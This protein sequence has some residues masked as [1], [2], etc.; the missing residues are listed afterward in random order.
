M[1]VALFILF[2]TLYL[3][4][5]SQTVWTENNNGLPTKPAS[6]VSLTSDGTTLLASNKK[7][8]SVSYDEGNTW[9]ELRE[10]FSFWDNHKFIKQFGNRLFLSTDNSGLMLSYDG[11]QSW[12]YAS[13]LPLSKSVT[14]MAEADTNFYLGTTQGVYTMSKADG[15][16]MPLSFGISSDTYINDV[17][18]ANNVIFA[19]TNFGVYLS[20]NWGKTWALASGIPSDGSVRSIAALQNTIVVATSKGLFLSKD[21]GKNWAV[22]GKTILNESTVYSVASYNNKVFILTLT[23][24]YSS[25]DQGETWKIVADNLN[26]IKSLTVQDNKLFLLTN[27]GLFKLDNS[28][29]TFKSSDHGMPSEYMKINDIEGNTYNLFSST[30]KGLYSSVDNGLVWK[31]C[32]MNGG[33]ITGVN[34]ISVSGNMVFAMNNSF[35]IMSN[36]KGLTW[37]TTGEEILNEQTPF[38]MVEKINGFFY[39]VSET[40]G[41][42]NSSDGVQWT[43][44]TKEFPKPAFIQTYTWCNGVLYVG[45]LSGLY[46]FSLDGKWVSIDKG[47]PSKNIPS[48]TSI[49]KSVFAG[50]DDGVY[51]KNKD[52]SW[53]FSGI[54]LKED[55]PV[56][57]LA[58]SGKYLFADL[59]GELYLSIDSG[60]YWA[61]Y[62]FLNYSFISSTS[63]ADDSHIFF[64]TES[65]GI[66]SISDPSKLLGMLTASSNEPAVSSIIA[67]PSMVGSISIEAPETG[68]YLLIRKAWA[69]SGTF[70]FKTSCNVYYD[71]DFRNQDNV[72]VNKQS[73]TNI[74][75]LFL[76]AN[77]LDFPLIKSRLESSVPDDVDKNTFL[78]IEYRKNGK[79]YKICWDTKEKS[80]N[81]Y[82]LNKLVEDAKVLW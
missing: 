54:G 43:L 55:F 28:S 57:H 53:S 10:Q 67:E 18:V 14:C 69:S 62:D 77:K 72:N 82:L 42:F 63:F 4:G 21:N 75:S 41:V 30:E 74:A 7:G 33:S 78:V 73:K 19:G 22:T 39:A 66:I 71:Y 65:S 47:L 50:T 68:D 32:L 51:K 56:H 48:L 34:N 45:T 60:R 64:G 17:L 5:I 6:V 44:L 9:N 29:N 58:T 80:L 40:G 23:K 24:M 27:N 81:A 12:K 16:V 37:K 52:D 59:Y 13:T 20:S 36:D 1:K 25:E 61:S 35:I 3:N 46:R 15:K 38:V 8:I 26:K 76:K 70:V 49:G 11:G 79:L 2:I 31:E